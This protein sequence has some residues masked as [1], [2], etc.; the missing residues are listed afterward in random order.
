MWTCLMKVQLNFQSRAREGYMLRGLLMFPLWSPQGLCSSESS[1]GEGLS[2]KPM[3]I[4]SVKEP[5]DIA[6]VFISSSA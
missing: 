5:V 3:I 6:C 4:L 2:L 1:E